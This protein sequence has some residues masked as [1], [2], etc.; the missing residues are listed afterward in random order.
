MLEPEVEGPISLRVPLIFG[1]AEAVQA[2]IDAGVDHSSVM[3]GV[4]VVGD[5]PTLSVFIEGGSDVEHENEGISALALAAYVGNGE[6]IE[7]LVNKG[8]DK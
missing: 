3:H 5:I 7:V 2:L 6:A 8:A 1:L 4:V